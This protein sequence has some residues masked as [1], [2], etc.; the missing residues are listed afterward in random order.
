MA[1]HTVHEGT[2]YEETTVDHYMWTTNLHKQPQNNSFD[3]K[4]K[5]YQI[6]QLCDIVYIMDLV[7]GN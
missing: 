2:A 5:N 1:F 4:K 6:I 3:T 7:V